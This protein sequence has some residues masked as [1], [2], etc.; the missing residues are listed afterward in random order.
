MDVT[1]HRTF[2]LLING[3]GVAGNTYFDVINPATE[4]IVGRAPDATRAQ[5][6]AAVAA[7]RKASAAWKAIP[8]AER[9]AKVAA[10]GGV[11]AA[12]VDELKRLL[13]A[14][15]GKVLGDA[16]QDVLGGAHFC[17]HF[18][19]L[20]P[21]VEVHEDSADR[22]SATYRVPLGVVCAIAPWNFPI[23]I[24]FMKIAPALVAGNS[25]VL[26]PSPFTPLTTLRIA[27]LVRDVLPPGVLNVL[28]GGDELGPW[29]TSHPG[30]NKISFT[31]STATGR[32]VMASAAPTLKRVTLELGGNDAAI[33]LPG[34]NV[35]AAAEQVFRAA[36]G[37]SGQIC[38]AAK[39]VYVHNDVYEPFAAAMVK[40][41]QEAK[42]GDGAKEGTDF[43]PIQNRQQYERVK[44]LIA[45]CR[46]NGHKFL[47]GEHAETP[48]KGY[49]I[50]LTILDDPPEDSRIVR[51][52][53]F[54][55][56]LPL[57]RYDDLDAVVEKAND[58]DYGLGGSVWG[59]PEQAEAVAHR[60]DTGMV[61]V[62]EYG[63]LAPSQP[64]G[65]R[66][67]SG[68]GVE[69]GMAGLLEFTTIHTIVTAKKVGV[70]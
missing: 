32:R 64:F 21:P 28:S 37:N 2:E 60:L 1:S 66:K 57:L 58:S 33:V 4:E 62:N 45:D 29:M 61:W 46:A 55:P 5:L 68:F 23:A 42:V 11:I 59:P 53:Q 47:L 63:S 17:H 26:K 40:L 31:G 13:T 18:A 67:Q 54:G 22:R 43:G 50:P 35:Q 34:V 38:F 3:V 65:G 44:D 8:I 27:E 20:T 41:G 16:E 51:E 24:A 49:F 25:V 9:Q 7:A 6:D 69:H 30:F 14:E 39:R 56:V 36:F 15:Q 70:T 10:M 19:E 48:A 12:N 52:E